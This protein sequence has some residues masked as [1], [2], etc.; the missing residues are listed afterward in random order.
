MELFA[1][2]VAAMLD[3]AG[4]AE[5]VTVCGLS[6]GGCVALAF[7]RKYASRVRSLVLCDA[8]AAADTPEAAANRHTMADKVLT[9]GPR[10]AAEAMLPRLFASET[11]EKQP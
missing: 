9:D 10:V 5:P 6:M 2:D 4:V 1:D 11:N 7:V 8:R 3:A